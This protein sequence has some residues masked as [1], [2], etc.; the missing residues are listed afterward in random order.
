MGSIIGQTGNENRVEDFKRLCYVSL[1][2]S[3]AG[4]AEAWRLE[5]KREWSLFHGED[6]SDPSA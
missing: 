3:E 5:A 4:Q 6:Q 1:E 2:P